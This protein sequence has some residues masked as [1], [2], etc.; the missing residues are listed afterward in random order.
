MKKLFYIFT[1]FL[2]CSCSGSDEQ[3][4]PLPNPQPAKVLEIRGADFSFLP[5]VR[6]SGQIFY[7]QNNVAEDMLTTFKNAGGNVV[8]L[9]LW[10]NPATPTSGFDS[11]K[12][13][14]QEIKNKGMKVMIS[15]HYS[16]SWADP[17]NQTK[18]AAWQND[19]FEQLKTDVYNYTKQIV[20]QIN[21]E[22]IQIGN[23]INNGMLWPEGNIQNLAQFK[24]LLQSGISAV[25]DT[26]TS[27]KII[28]HFAGIDGSQAFFNNISD[29]NFDIIGLSYYPIWH[30]KDLTQLQNSMTA[31][32]N[33]SNKPILIAET[34]Y[35]FTFNWNDQ[36]QNIVG[37]N[38]QIIAQFPATEAGQR[39]FL[40]KIKQISTEVPKGIGFCYWGTEW[41][42]YKGTTA[43]DGSS[44]EN[45]ALWKFNNKAVP[46]M[47]A[48]NNN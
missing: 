39:D 23:E 40:K 34:S 46:A 26:N 36:T 38:S 44:Y 19:T 18:P 29:L 37:D 28:I 43:T 6:Q 35:P 1:I 33:S 42:A 17:G 22:Y 47:E 27:T 24:G 13:L 15:V 3:P 25:R 12:N 16:D 21:P 8:R 20:S 2:L 5:E 4:S 45:Q 11:V 31:L 9:R 10:V 30:G 41:T 32:S 14:A 7:N 48:F